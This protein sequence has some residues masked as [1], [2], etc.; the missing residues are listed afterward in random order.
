MT[1]QETS[2]QSGP[3]E[4]G[5]LGRV[6]RLFSK[7]ENFTNW[8]SAITIML[9][10]FMAVYQIVGRRIFNA[11]IFGYIDIIEQLMII[12]AISGIAYCQRLGGHV[13]MELII[14]RIGRGR[15]YWLVEFLAILASIVFI[16]IMIPET[17]KHFLRAWNLGDSTINANLPL[18]PAKLLVPVAFSIL[19]VRLLLNLLGY[20]RLMIDP[21]AVPVAIPLIQHI[22][23]EAAREIHDAL[24]EDVDVHFSHED[25]DNAAR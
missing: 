5:W 6:D 12:F 2:P 15:F 19:W 7:V 11:P 24:G 14:D 25:H 4:G 21:N 1:Q 10:M 17:F 18:W 3:V 23:D 8:I 16:S 20:L 13:R 22:E 9:L